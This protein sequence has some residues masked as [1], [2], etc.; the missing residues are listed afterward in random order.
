MKCVL[1]TVVDKVAKVAGNPMVF[2]ND[3]DAARYWEEVVCKQPVPSA[4]PADFVWIK[5]GIFDRF[6]GEI[7]HE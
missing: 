6:T 3:D 7:T 2:Q 1:Y 4:R 5:C